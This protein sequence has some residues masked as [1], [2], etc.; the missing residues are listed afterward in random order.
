NLLG[1]F[2]KFLETKFNFE[3]LDIRLLN[4]GEKDIC[5]KYI[6][7]VKWDQGHYKYSGGRP[8]ALLVAYDYHPEALN[9]MDLKK[10]S[11]MTNKNN[12]LAKYKF[13]EHI[14]QLSI[15]RSHYNGI[16]S[17]DNEFD[18]KYYLFLLGKDYLRTILKKTEKLRDRYHTK[19]SVVKLISNSHLSKVELIK[20]KTDI[21]IKKTFRLGREKFFQ[22][23]LFAT[24][25]LSK[26]LSFIP[27]LLERGEG[28]LILPFIIDKS[29]N[30]TPIE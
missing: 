4:A 2:K 9:E 14:N 11:R 28:Y 5:S 26:E 21:A 1:E 17:A 6:R 7:G 12:L 23:E 29:K 24:Q 3:I 13:R 19:Y 30:L 20:Y 27:R 16:H 8:E 15:K 22:R 25:E 18:A 10:Q